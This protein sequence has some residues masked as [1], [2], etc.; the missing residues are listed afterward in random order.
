MPDG[1]RLAGRARRRRRE[2]VAPPARRDVSGTVARRVAGSTA[3]QPAPPAALA[4]RVCAPCSARSR[5]DAAE[6]TAPA[7]R[8][9]G[10]AR[11]S[12]RAAR[13]RLHVARDA[14]DLLAADALVTYAFEL[15]S[16]RPRRSTRA[17]RDA[18]R[19]IAALAGGAAPR[20]RVA[21]S[22]PRAA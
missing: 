7:L 1:A 3:A 10:G 14:L 15:A 21:A 8:G 20:E 22:A 12:A 11:C 13:R 19:R 5:R 18:M 9:R 16:E 17:R 4:R 2:L 6:A